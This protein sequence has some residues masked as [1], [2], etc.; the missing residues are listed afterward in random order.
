MVTAIKSTHKIFKSAAYQKDI[1]PFQLMEIIRPAPM[2][3]LSNRKDFVIGMSAPQMPIWVWTADEISE[4]SVNELCNT[5]YKR[6]KNGDSGVYFVAK[7]AVANQLA[8]PFIKHF[9]ADEH[10]VSMESFENRAVFPP[11]NQE[12][13]IE[14]PTSADI[15][16]IAE[17]MAGF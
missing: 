6:F 3:L 16:D 14:R 12:V 10:R 4:N 8:E 13:L 5:F 2:L 17:C 11:K 1:V 7:P 15:A 9:H